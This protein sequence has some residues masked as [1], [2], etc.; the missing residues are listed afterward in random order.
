MG[1]MAE[2]S[3]ELP[4]LG[5]ELPLLGH[6][7]AQRQNLISY[8][9]I[10]YPTSKFDVIVASSQQNLEEMKKKSRMRDMRIRY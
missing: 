1:V 3:I 6:F 8:V 4:N 10:L 7:D 9:K 2:N 5:R